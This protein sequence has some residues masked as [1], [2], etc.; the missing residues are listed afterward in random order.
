MHCRQNKAT[1]GSNAALGDVV[2]RV[3][4]SCGCLSIPGHPTAGSQSRRGRT[5]VQRA[6]WPCVTLRRRERARL[7]DARGRAARGTAGSRGA[8]R[9]CGACTGSATRQCVQPCSATS[10]RAAGRA[11][12][13]IVRSSRAHPPSSTSW[14]PS[15]ST[16]F[17]AA[18][19]ACRRLRRPRRCRMY[20]ARRLPPT[21]PLPNAAVACGARR[22]TLAA[23]AWQRVREQVPGHQDGDREGFPGTDDRDWRGHPGRHWLS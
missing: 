23:A 5:R 19:G 18:P 15:L 10:A 22:L 1:V 13:I 21:A 11:H 3:R 2:K 20:G 17:T 4:T 8:A 12:L 9:R 14:L 16:L 7:S 6:P